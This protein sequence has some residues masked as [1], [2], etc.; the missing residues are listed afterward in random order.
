[1]KTT[2]SLFIAALLLISC[3]SDTEQKGLDRIA[4]IYDAKAT[5]TKGFNS[6]V[7]EETVRRFTV[8]VSESRM[9]DSLNPNVTSANIAVIIFQGMSEEERDQYNNIDVEMVNKDN[10]T[11]SYTYPN[12]VLK[13]LV[14]KAANFERFSKAMVDGDGGTIDLIRN[15]EF[16]SEPIGNKVINALGK[17]KEA[18]GILMDYA[19]FGVAEISDESGAAY[20]FQSNLI[21]NDGFKLPYIVVIDTRPGN[22]KVAGFRI[23]E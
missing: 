19:P 17:H 12:D 18:H 9:I 14:A 20:Q 15:T 13:K 7:G 8:K 16:I 11:A 4:D 2:L 21:F 6:S 1:M 3:A 22:N 10:D 23:F 5:Y